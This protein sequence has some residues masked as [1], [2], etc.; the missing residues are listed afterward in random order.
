M[1]EERQQLLSPNSSIYNTSSYGSDTGEPELDDPRASVV[2]EDGD[3]DSR[4][5]PAAQQAG[6]ASSIF[7][8]VNVI[9]GGTRAPRPATRPSHRYVDAQSA[10]L[11]VLRSISSEG[12]RDINANKLDRA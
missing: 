10:C 7:N 12:Y 3:L 4:A 9:V 6:M 1:T 11:R 2:S 8:L 5:T